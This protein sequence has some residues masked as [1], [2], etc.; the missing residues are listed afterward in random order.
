M[1][2][3][4]RYLISSREISLLAKTSLDI[5]HEKVDRAKRIL[6]TRTLAATV[7]AALDEVINLQARRRLMDR[8]RREGGIGPSPEEL[9]RLREP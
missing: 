9:R 5:D 4:V 8:I 2:A 3:I 7:D 1:L 6:G